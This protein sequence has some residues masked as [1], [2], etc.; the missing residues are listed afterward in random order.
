MPGN[1]IWLQDTI[2]NK[3]PWTVSHIWTQIDETT[4]EGGSVQPTWIHPTVILMGYQRTN[5]PNWIG[6][7]GPLMTHEDDLRGT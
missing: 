5:K 4:V 3:G 7:C 1:L 6:V 2:E